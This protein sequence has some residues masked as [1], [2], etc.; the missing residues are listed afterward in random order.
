VEAFGKQ[1]GFKM[2]D[3]ALAFTHAGDRVVLVINRTADFTILEFTIT[4]AI[5]LYSD[6]HA[7]IINAAVQP[8]TPPLLDVRKP[9]VCP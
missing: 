6:M 4:E 3:T 2:T 5:G 9:P 1:G 8:T 7:A